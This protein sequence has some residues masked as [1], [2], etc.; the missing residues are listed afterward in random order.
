MFLC[1]DMYCLYGNI[2]HC[3]VFDL[4]DFWFLG[5]INIIRIST[6]WN[7]Y[8][9][10]CIINIVIYF[11]LHIATLPFRMPGAWCKRTQLHPPHGRM[12]GHQVFLPYHFGRRVGEVFFEHTQNPLKM[13]KFWWFWRYIIFTLYI[14]YKYRL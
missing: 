6:Q 14:M 7:W 8:I 10:K 11:I 9:W 2:P 1:I 13:L 12:H 4:Y 3:P 5:F